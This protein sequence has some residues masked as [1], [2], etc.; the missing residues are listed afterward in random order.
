MTEGLESTN[1]P[2]NLLQQ[3]WTGIIGPRWPKSRLKDHGRSV[4]LSCLPMNFDPLVS[5]SLELC[6]WWTRLGNAH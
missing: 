1:V 3:Q 6:N 2:A 4:I 5:V